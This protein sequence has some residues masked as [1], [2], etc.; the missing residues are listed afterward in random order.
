[1]KNQVEVKRLVEDVWLDEKFGA[2]GF[3]FIIGY[4]KSFQDFRRRPFAG[5]RS[6][7]PSRIQLIDLRLDVLLTRS[8]RVRWGGLSSFLF[9]QAHDLLAS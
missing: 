4:S 1:M 2:L 8:P 5:S 6:L 9:S 3:T 7:L